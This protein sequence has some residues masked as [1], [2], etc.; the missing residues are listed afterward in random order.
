MDI[1]EHPEYPAVPELNKFVE[2]IDEYNAIAKFLDWAADEKI[3]NIV[4]APKIICEF[5]GVDWDEME[6]ERA[7]ILDFLH[8]QY[9]FPGTLLS[10]VKM[11]ATF[12]DGEE[13]KIE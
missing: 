8:K 11:T 9:P 1:T 2:M 4:N 7:A 12:E 10:D 6:R 5:L 3:M 13:M